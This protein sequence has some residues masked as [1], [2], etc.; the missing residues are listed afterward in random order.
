MTVQKDWL[1]LEQSDICCC[2]CCFFIMDA[3]FRPDV[4][5]SLTRCHLIRFF[6]F[7]ESNVSDIYICMLSYE[8]NDNVNTFLDL[9]ITDKQT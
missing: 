8:F 6:F 4:F 3:V 1:S 5:L 9:M 2:C 7:K